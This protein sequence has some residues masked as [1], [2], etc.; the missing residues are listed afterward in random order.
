MSGYPFENHNQH[1]APVPLEQAD[2]SRPPPPNAR[3]PGVAPVY[4]IVNSNAQQSNNYSIP[5]NVQMNL[6]ANLPPNINPPLEHQSGVVRREPVPMSADERG[7]SNYA[8]PCHLPRNDNANLHGNSNRGFSNYAVPH[9]MPRNEN[10]TLSHNDSSCLEFESSAVRRE[11]NLMGAHERGFLNYALAHQMPMGANAFLP[12]TGTPP[13]QFESASSRMDAQGRA[14]LN[15]AIPHHMHSADTK[16]ILPRIPFMQLESGGTSREAD[17]FYGQATGFYNAAIPQMEGARPMA[18]G[19]TRV[20]ELVENVAA[21]R[22]MTTNYDQQQHSRQQL[23]AISWKHDED[24]NVPPAAPQLRRSARH[25]AER[26][27]TINNQAVEAGYVVSSKQK[28][29]APV[30]T[31]SHVEPQASE[32]DQDDERNGRKADTAGPSVSREN[33]ES[34]SGESERDELG[35]WMDGEDDLSSDFEPKKKIS[36]CNQQRKSNA[37]NDKAPKNRRVENEADSDEEIAR[38]QQRCKPKQRKNSE[39]RRQVKPKPL[40]DSDEEFEA[41]AREKL[42]QTSKKM[43]SLNNKSKKAEPAEPKFRTQTE[44][45][46]DNDLADIPDNN[47]VV[48]SSDSERNSSTGLPAAELFPTEADNQP[49]TESNFVIPPK[50]LGE[51]WCT[52]CFEDY[53]EEVS[54]LGILNP[55]HCYRFCYVCAVRVS[56]SLDP[57]CPRCRENIDSVH[58]QRYQKILLEEDWCL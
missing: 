25:A 52:V 17:I 38:V 19:R 29:P 30:P 33:R 27:V 34:D 26:A 18:L 28:R 47:F 3:H 36:K 12:R 7:F 43:Q 32:S 4:V 35:R 11:P 15:F 21:D 48:I 51:E 45:D 6:N 54:Y 39:S 56:E 5:H 20:T 50:S 1:S 14:M 55:C 9:V 37:K 31:R 16:A 41:E 24:S 13:L 22:S 46:P 40:S 44:S 2:F 53:E 10:A 49:T 23:P 57:T 42:G 8:I 58:S